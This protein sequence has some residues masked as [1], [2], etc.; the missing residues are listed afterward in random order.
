M[1]GDDWDY[2]NSRLAGTV[3]R[4]ADE[5]VFVH[6]IGED[7]I[8]KLC[9]LSSL[10]EPFEEKADLLN[11]QPV[12]LGMCNFSGKA[13]YLARI[14]MR[15]DWKQGLRKENFMSHSGIPH[16]LIPP[17][18]LG[19]T[20]QGKYPSFDECVASFKDAEVVSVAW[21]RHWAI[22][23]TF[24]LMYKDEYEPVGKY[25]DGIYVLN[26]GFKHLQ[27]ALEESL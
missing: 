12:P 3:V 23:R 2:A 27:E 13:N 19:L 6:Y 14:P 25:I 18:V 9:K 21:H 17:D 16:V 10:H 7:M 11:L 22:T 20:I 15:K 5:P 1:Y 8:A 26:D 4:L 24:D